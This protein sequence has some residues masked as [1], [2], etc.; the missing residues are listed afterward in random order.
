MEQFESESV[1]KSGG[2]EKEPVIQGE[3]G[4]IKP[5]MF[6][7]SY[8]EFLEN[9]G[10]PEEFKEELIKL[11]GETDFSQ[12]EEQ[13]SGMMHT[14]HPYESYLELERSMPDDRLGYKLLLMQTECAYRDA[15]NYKAQGIPAE[16][17]YDT[18][19]CFTR[20]VGEYKMVNGCYGFSLGWW[21]FR[22]LNMTLFRLGTLEYEFILK[23]GVDSEKRISVH[24]PA[25]ADISTES[26]VN[27]LEKM[28]A[29]AVKFYPV[30]IGSTIMCESWLLS[31]ELG[32]LLKP[33]SRIAQFASMFDI[34]E[35]IEDN[36]DYKYFLFRVPDDTKTEDL[37]TNTGLQKRVKEHLLEYGK[38]GVAAG[39]LKEEYI[40]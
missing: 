23:E 39:N 21:A 4:E 28:K 19:S 17:Y 35:V 25:G 13:L 8:R 11:Y 24:I 37:P 38:I 33:D 16:I 5:A 27:S 14:A 1:H 10:F 6:P 15:E 36:E 34:T 40:Q 12:Y 20:F 32:K 29:F 18:F 7:C 26:V 22:Q 2:T 3:C 31:P 9:I 30:F